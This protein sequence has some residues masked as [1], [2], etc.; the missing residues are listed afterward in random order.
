MLP[1]GSF[2]GAPEEGLDCACV[3]YLNDVSA[4]TEAR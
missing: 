2:T 1:S 4:W 3:L